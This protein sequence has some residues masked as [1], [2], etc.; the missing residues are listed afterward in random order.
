MVLILKNERKLDFLVKETK[1]DKNK[2]LKM[3]TDLE[4]EFKGPQNFKARDGRPPSLT[5]R[6]ALTLSNS[7]YSWMYCVHK[8]TINLL[9]QLHHETLHADVFSI[10]RLSG[11]GYGH[12]SSFKRR[13]WLSGWNLQNRTIVVGTVGLAPILNSVM[14]FGLKEIQSFC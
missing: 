11:I 8:N 3:Y 14:D 1:L 9:Q 7:R 13:P 4:T 5:S 10:W 2:R 6:L 12:V